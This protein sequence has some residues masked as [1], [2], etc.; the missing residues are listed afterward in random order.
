MRR[1]GGDDEESARAPLRVAAKRLAATRSG[2]RIASYLI[3][4]NSIS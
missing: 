1:R 3:L 4:I 2:A